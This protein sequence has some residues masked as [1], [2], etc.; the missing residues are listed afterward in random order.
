MWWCGR[1]D[2]RGEEGRKFGG[3][4]L[5]IRGEEGG[6]EVVKGDEIVVKKKISKIVEERDG[7]VRERVERIIDKKKKKKGTHIYY[8]INK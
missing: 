2:T 4:W 6:V 3:D 7:E 1:T 8:K 5:V